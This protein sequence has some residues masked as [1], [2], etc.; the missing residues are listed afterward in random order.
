MC[1]CIISFR[2]KDDEKVNNNKVKFQIDTIIF[3]NLNVCIKNP[4]HLS[5]HRDDIDD[6]SSAGLAYFQEGQGYALDM[7]HQTETGTKILV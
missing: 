7:L 4:Q 6:D 2:K 1:V 3:K 5:F